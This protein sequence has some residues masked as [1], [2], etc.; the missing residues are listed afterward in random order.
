MILRLSYRPRHLERGGV[1]NL[2]YTVRYLASTYLLLTLFA[3]L[4][5][6]MPVT[7]G[8]SRTA[9]YGN[10][11]HLGASGYHLYRRSLVPCSPALALI[12]ARAEG[13]STLVPPMLYAMYAYYVTCSRTSVLFT[14]IINTAL[15][16]ISARAEGSHF[17]ALYRPSVCV[18]LHPFRFRLHHLRPRLI[19]TVLSCTCSN[20]IIRSIEM[21]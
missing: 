16:L 11:P 20:M 10:F 7:Y 4:R 6:S 14:G 13:V 5:S 3:Y 18:C 15:A 2:G 17:C 12:S 19:R 9:Q 1:L 8:R 21:I